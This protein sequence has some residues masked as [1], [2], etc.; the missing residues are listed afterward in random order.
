[1]LKNQ[2]LIEARPIAKR[3]LSLGKCITNIAK[4]HAIELLKV[5]LM[6]LRAGNY[7]LIRAEELNELFKKLDRN[8]FEQT[9]KD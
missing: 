1:M 6:P 9:R 3:T 2:E 4:W 8:S 5:V 7:Y